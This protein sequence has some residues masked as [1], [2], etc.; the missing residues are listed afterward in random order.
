MTAD[1]VRVVK[2]PA[3]AAGSRASA[4]GQFPSRSSTATHHSN[5][6]EALSPKGPLADDR[7]V[8]GGHESELDNRKR[9]VI[10]SAESMNK[11]KLCFLVT[12]L[13]V[14]YL[15]PAVIRRALPAL[16]IS[17]ALH[18]HSAEIAANQKAPDLTEYT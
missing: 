9:K 8:P 16:V 11:R 10:L 3:E 5:Q 17:L 1:S 18:A 6:T 2:R 14:P 12:P 13:V 15:R 7:R 4:R